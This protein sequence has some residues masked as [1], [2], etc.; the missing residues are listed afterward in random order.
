MHNVWIQRL[1]VNT[2]ML[3]TISCLQFYPVVNSGIGTKKYS[4]GGKST[5]KLSCDSC[6]YKFLIVLL[7]HLIGLQNRK[8]FTVALLFKK[9]H[10]LLYWQVVAYSWD[11]VNVNTS[12]VDGPP[13]FLSASRPNRGTTAAVAAWNCYLVCCGLIIC[14]TWTMFLW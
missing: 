8:S 1:D 14:K 11:Y 6:Y 13:N 4:F 9:T 10:L 5:N 7:V 12:A 3:L 2:T